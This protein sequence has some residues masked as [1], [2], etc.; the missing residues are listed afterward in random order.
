MG[1]IPGSDF[2][3]KWDCPS[4]EDLTSYQQR[5]LANWQNSH[6]VTHLAKCDYC[7]AELQLLSKFPLADYSYESPPMPASLRALAEALLASESVRRQGLRR[8]LRED[9]PV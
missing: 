1:S 9:G 2:K 5:N 8:M 6:I 7:A 3:K 4:S